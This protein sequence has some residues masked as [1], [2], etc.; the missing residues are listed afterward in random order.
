MNISKKIFFLYIFIILFLFNCKIGKVNEKN[1]IQQNNCL[2]SYIKGKAFLTDEQFN[3]ISELKTGL[4]LKENDIVKTEKDSIIELNIG[5]ESIVRIK[6]NSILKIAKLFKDK[7]LEETKL[8]LDL[9]KILAKPKNLTEGSSFEIETNSVTAGVRGTEF[10][11]YQSDAGDAKIAVNEGKVYIDKNIISPEINKIKKFDEELAGS[12]ESLLQE[13]L[14]LQ[15]NEKLIVNNVEYNAFREETKNKINEILEN[16]EANKNS[17]TKIESIIKEAK[18]KTIKNI[19]SKSN[20]IIYKEEV[21]ETEWQKDFNREEFKE[22]GTGAA[23][24]NEGK[25]KKIEKLVKDKEIKKENKLDEKKEEKIEKEEITVIKKL[26]LNLGVSLSEKNTS[27]TSD[28]KDIYITNDP[29]KTIYCIDPEQIKLRWKFSDP[30]INKIHSPATPFKNKVIL[31]TYNDIFLLN[32]SGKILLNKKISNGP[33]YWASPIKFQDKIFI[34]SARYLYFYDGNTIEQIDES[35][36][37]A[38]LSQLY[39]GTDSKLIFAVDSL[40]CTIKIYDFMN[41][42]IQWSSNKLPN[43]IFSAPVMAGKYLIAGDIKQN[44]YRFDYQSNETEPDILEINSGILSNIISIGSNIYFV[45]KDGLF[46][47][48]N[49]NVFNNAKIII[50]VDNTPMQDKYL[51]KRLLRDGNILYFASDSGKLFTYNVSTQEANLLEIKDN[52]DNL[53]LIGTPIKIK[54]AIYIFDEKANIY[55]RYKTSM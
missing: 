22:I 37:P 53:A 15:K 41:K 29:D 55:K 2:V 3:N 27:I 19:Q 46:Y 18:E 54:D 25:E 51:I 11:V 20:E 33:L 48:V 50:R 30:K 38:A 47:T 36:F 35:E 49:I 26:P 1:Q 6:E 10:T 45:A 34:P 40:N 8:N 42:N 31:A 7:D 5:E 43:N 44:L 13:Q 14:I 12:L 52:K 21:K 9:G 32:D 39:I 28:G 23:S 16:L 4:Y 17:K 24:V